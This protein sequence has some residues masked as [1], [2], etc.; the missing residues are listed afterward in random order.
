MIKTKGT[1]GR[2]K[3]KFTLDPAVGARTAS[4]CGEWNG[5]TA[6]AHPMKRDSKGGFSTTLELEAGRE[7]RFRY[8]LDGE[9]WENDWE[10]DAYLPNDFGA[11]DSVIDL[12]DHATEPAAKRASKRAPAAASEGS[13]AKA[14]TASKRSRATK[15]SAG[16]PPTDGGTTEAAAKPGP[17]KAA[18]PAKKATKRQG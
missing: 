14:A 4:I 6:D 12:T 16:A 15:Q 13:P 18:R 5:W 8:L 7:Y 17:A 3:V 9:R 10:A 2:A 11:E 1:Y